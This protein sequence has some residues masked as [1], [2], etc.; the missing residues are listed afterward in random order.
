M[1]KTIK[2]TS[3]KI[4]KIIKD[5]K[6]TIDLDTPDTMAMYFVHGI[7]AGSFTQRLIDGRTYSKETILSHAH[8]LLHPYIDDYIELKRLLTKEFNILPCKNT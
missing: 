8:P 3:D 4:K 6:L 1:Q 7:H 5:N 2:P